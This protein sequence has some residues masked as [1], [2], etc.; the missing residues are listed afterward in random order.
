MLKN[1]ELSD[2]YQGRVKFGVWA[3]GSVSFFWLL[4]GEVKK[5]TFQLSCAQPEVTNL[6]MLLLL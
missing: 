1:P 2:S 4:C 5:V 6:H 3:T